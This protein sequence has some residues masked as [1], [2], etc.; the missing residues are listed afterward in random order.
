MRA[1][2]K[3]PR[4]W[5]APHPAGLASHPVDAKKYLNRVEQIQKD[6]D[7]AR[8][9]V[10]HDVRVTSDGVILAFRVAPRSRILFVDGTSLTV[11]YEHAERVPG[12]R[13]VALT[14]YSYHYQGQRAFRVDKERPTEG[15]HM[16][17]DK[18]G[19]LQSLTGTPIDLSYVNLFSFY[20][21]CREYRRSGDYPPDPAH[22]PKYRRIVEHAWRAVR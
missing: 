9:D 8:F 3:R 6:N 16:N 20:Y 17:D 2:R 11:N 7:I 1:R 10:T 12:T 13:K 18:H 19:H 22:G 5:V 14:T 4:V 21:M 15:P